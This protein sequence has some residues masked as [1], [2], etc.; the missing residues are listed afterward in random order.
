MASR[1]RIVQVLVA[2]VTLV[3]GM[4]PAQSR[5]IE[6]LAAGKLLVMEPQDADPVF[7][8]S[9]IL[10]IHYDTDGVVGLRLNQPSRAPLSRLREVNGTAK[11]SDPAYI[12]GPVRIEEVTALVRAPSAPR[13]AMH[14]TA[15][16]Y[17]VQTKSALEA[18]LKESTGPA[19]LRVYL[20]YCG[21]VIPQL[22]SEVTRGS[23]Y[24]FDRGERFA[25][26]SAPGTLWKRLI[27][28][29]NLRLALTP[30]SASYPS[31]Q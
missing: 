6:D 31:R 12:G 7:A 5:R 4:L 14:V 25:F 24:I 11:R 21:W 1:W 29:T 10:L 30:N 22:K 15:D 26:D 28:L 13:D 8:E 3:C 27:E 2:S 19:D 20:G 16:L 23:W 17:A 18:A 9:V